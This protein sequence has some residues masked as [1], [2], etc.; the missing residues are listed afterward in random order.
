MGGMTGMPVMGGVSFGPT[1]GMMPGR[2]LDLA[3]STQR[4]P[5]DTEA[6]QTIPPGQAMGPSLTL[7]PVKAQAERPS[8]R[9]DSVKKVPERPKAASCFT[10]AAAAAC[11][12]ARHAFW[13]LPKPAWKTTASSCWAVPPATPV[14]R[15]CPVMP[16]GKETHRHKVPPQASLTG[17]HALD[18]DGLPASLQFAIGQAQ[19]FMPKLA[20]VTQ[21]GGAAGRP[22]RRLGQAVQHHNT[23]ASGPVTTARRKEQ[24]PNTVW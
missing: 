4:K 16:S 24:M 22:A 5:A 18:G 14:P 17:Q 6:L 11:A 3:V 19:D 8:Q 20:L 23:A 9:G 10:G 7:L 12:P 2:W 21:G 13:T 15:P 1:R